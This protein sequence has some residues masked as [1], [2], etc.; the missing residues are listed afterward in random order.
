MTAYSPTT[1]TLAQTQPSFDAEAVRSTLEKVVSSVFNVNAL[2]Q[3]LA[4][5]LAAFIAIKILTFLLRR[6][7]HQFRKRADATKNLNTVNRLR[8]YETLTIVGIAI[9]R[10]LVMIFAFYFWWVLTHREGNHSNALIGASALAVV[11]VGGVAGPLLRDFAFGFGMMAEGWFRVGDLVSIEFPN[12]Q[13]VVE[14][15]TLR[16]TRIRGL[17]GEVIWIANQTIT[18]VR[19]AQKGVWATA[20]ELF[21]TDPERAKVLVGTVNKLL[22]GGMT[23]LVTPLEI[24]DIEQTDE[25]IWHITAIGETVPGREW[26]LTDSAVE[27]CKKLDEKS[28]DPI[29]IVDP[30]TRYADKETE[31]Q[32]IRAVKNARKKQHKLNYRQLLNTNLMHTKGMYPLNAE[33]II[34]PLQTLTGDRPAG[35]IRGEQPA[36]PA[37]DA[38]AGSARKDT[39]EAPKR[40]A[41]RQ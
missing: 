23:L 6:L 13:G 4:V 36:P 19:V 34:R 27:I 24:V 5:L 3:L 2:L 21:V 38:T 1:H 7:S 41:G 37:G 40:S 10:L 9:L 22:P 30:V 39:G 14:R 35:D 33:K 15:I 17:N 11:I 32:F 20:L 31:R 16:S 29:L 12:V 28:K 26:I 8:H 25:Q 18:G